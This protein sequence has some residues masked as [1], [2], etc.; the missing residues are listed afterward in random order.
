MPAVRRAPSS[1]LALAVIVRA[2]HLDA[3]ADGFNSGAL[4]V[5]ILV[6]AIGHL[7]RVAPRTEYQQRAS[8]YLRS[9]LVRPGFHECIFGGG[10]YIVGRSIEPGPR[11][12]PDRGRVKAVGWVG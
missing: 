1:L 10:A 3:R 2:E 7:S 12:V 6:V 11:E 8:A 4:E 9:F 5:L